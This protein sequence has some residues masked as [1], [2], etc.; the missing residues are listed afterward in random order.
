[1][2][3]PRRLALLPGLLV[4][5]AAS[6]LGAGAADDPL[7]RGLVAIHSM[8]GC[9]L[10]DYSYV[11]IESLQP[12]YARDARVY[13]VNRDKSVKEWITAEV[14]SPRRVRLQRILFFTDLRGTVR[15]GSEIKHQTEDWEYDAP[16]LYEFVAPRTWQVRDLKPT[17][18]LWTRRVTNLDDGLRYQCAARWM[19]DTAYPEWS[20]SNY[21]PIPGRET[22][23]M[24]RV[25][26]DA[27]E[28]T[29][30]IIAYGQSWLERQD[31]VKTIHRDGVRTRLARE[32]GKNWSVRLPESE[33]EAA[34][35]FA[36]PRQAFW[37][38]L[39]EVWD[40]VLTGA[41]PFIEKAPAGQP[42]RFVKMNEVEEDYVGRDLS[43]PA[44]SR[45]ARDR[46]LKVIE[47]Y[48]GP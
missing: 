3:M 9:Y 32:V 43:D 47:A 12:G 45:P 13:D 40:E 22:R 21:A 2:S 23:D 1:M 4:L 6:A 37:R 36:R 16:F 24:R 7:A 10:V 28:R 19:G 30:R 26:Y 44:L 18:G 15:D 17:P 8:A 14:L 33:C 39:R 20:C 46:I 41:A 25:D 29:T 38:V 31:N 48:R 27:L 34:R 35:A 42:P 5:V 11:E